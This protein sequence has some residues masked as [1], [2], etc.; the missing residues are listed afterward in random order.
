ME[1]IK[2][3]LTVCPKCKGAVVA[4]SNVNKFQQVKFVSKSIFVMEHQQQEYWCATCQK[5]QKNDKQKKTFLE[6]PSIE[7]ELSPLA[8]FGSESSI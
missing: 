4:T 1:V 3:E 8:S 2:H 6:F 7:I 5:F